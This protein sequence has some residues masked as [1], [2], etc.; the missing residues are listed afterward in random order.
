[1]APAQRPVRKDQSRAKASTER[2][3]EAAA[4][5]RR[6][7]EEAAARREAAAKREPADAPKG[8][9]RRHRPTP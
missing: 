8:G 7:K 5:Q 3:E 2:A 1:M 6:L 4:H 9:P